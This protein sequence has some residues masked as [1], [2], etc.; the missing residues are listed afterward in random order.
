MAVIM[1]NESWTACK[2]N[3]AWCERAMLPSDGNLMKRDGGLEHKL[4]KEDGA[5]LSKEANA[6]R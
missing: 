6:M 2:S 1:T 4:D 5:N 3:K